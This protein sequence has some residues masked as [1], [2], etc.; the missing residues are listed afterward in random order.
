[1]IMDVKWTM[2]ARSAVG[3]VFFGIITLCTRCQ[4]SSE[5]HFLNLDQQSK[6]E[7]QDCQWMLIPNTSKIQLGWNGYNELFNCVL[8]TIFA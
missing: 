1:M 5:F 2:E 4:G 6:S 8:H 3:P 7:V